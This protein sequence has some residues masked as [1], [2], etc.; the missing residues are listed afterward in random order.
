MQITENLTVTGVYY[1]HLASDGEY[2]LVEKVPDQ[3]KSPEITPPVEELPESGGS[4]AWLFVVLIVIALGGVVFV[5]RQRI[6]A[7]YQEKVSGRVFKQGRMAEGKG[8][9]SL[10]VQPGHSE[11]HVMH[12]SSS[13]T[14]RLEAKRLLQSAIL[15]GKSLD[16]A[17]L[18]LLKKGYDSKLVEKVAEELQ[19]EKHKR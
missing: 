5:F 2:V 18:D 6:G 3:P 14:P 8:V 10:P 1:G 13:A 16:D 11:S 4:Y 9:E 19:R 7:F 17:K 12:R 15:G